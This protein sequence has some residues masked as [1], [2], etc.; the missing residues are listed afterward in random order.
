MGR[1][2]EIRIAFK[3]QAKALRQF[4]NM[5]VPV[6]SNGAGNATTTVGGG[7]DGTAAT[8][9]T[10]IRDAGGSATDAEAAPAAAAPKEEERERHTSKYFEAYMIK[11]Q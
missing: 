3:G 2:I 9:V 8:T 11:Q 1:D 10:T 6:G 5:L 7:N 4:R